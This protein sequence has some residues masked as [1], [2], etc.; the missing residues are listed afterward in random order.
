MNWDLY[1]RPD[2]SIDLL[3]AWAATFESK[4]N[5]DIAWATGYFQLIELM[6]PIAS[7]QAAAVAIASAE[8]I[9]MRRS[10]NAQ[11]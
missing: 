5:L 1:R 7:R 10:G 11:R 9:L 8:G 4:D 6:Q 3:K 2:G